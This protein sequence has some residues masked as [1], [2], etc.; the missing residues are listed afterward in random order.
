LLGV[1]DTLASIG[2]GDLAMRLLD[3]AKAREPD[4]AA[5]YMARAG[6]Q[7]LD[8]R[9]AEAESELRNYLA[10]HPR[11]PT[12][13]VALARVLA[14]S[15]NL[16]GARSVLGDLLKESPGALEPSALLASIELQKGQTAAAIKILDAAVAAAPGNGAAA[17]GAGTLLLSTRHPV[18]SIRYWALATRQRSEAGDFLRLSQ[19][20]SATGKSAE[21]RVTLD[22][23]LHLDPKNVEARV[24]LAELE[25]R[26]RQAGKALAILDALEP[27]AA[28]RIDVLVARADALLASGRGAEAYPLYQRAFE[29]TR[30]QI[31]VFQMFKSKLAAKMPQPEQPLKNWLLMA[32]Q[33]VL[34]RQTLAQYLMQTSDNAGAIAAYE[35]LVQLVPRDVMA[36][37]NLAWLLADRSPERA[38]QFARTAVKA[39]P[40]QKQVLETL[41]SILAKRGKLTEAVGLYATAIDA[42]EQD[43][44]V[45]YRYADALARSGDRAKAKVFVTRSLAAQA[46]FAERAAAEQL[47]TQLN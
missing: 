28:A 23:V 39:G 29:S 18:E 9:T 24:A 35:E 11:A 37:N 2:R 44:A 10:R 25:I 7:S 42:F 34:I 32:P 19:A 1:A 8:R 21:A 20:L 26:D 46:N 6:A 3:I 4:N 16:E 12:V 38:E 36:L 41:A 5:V 14:S 15:N 40:G 13:Q 45:L 22:Q 33:D 47:A 43:G 27:N 30:S 17:A 31:L